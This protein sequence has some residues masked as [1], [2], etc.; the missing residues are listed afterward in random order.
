MKSSVFQN[1]TP[2]EI[3]LKIKKVKALAESG[4]GGEKRSGPAFT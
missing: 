1:E 2:Q 4:I 3:L